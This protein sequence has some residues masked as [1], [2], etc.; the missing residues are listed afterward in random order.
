MTEPITPTVL[1]TDQL[2][3]RWILDSPASE[4]R[5]SNRTFWRLATV[6]GRFESFHGE[7]VVDAS[8]D[9]PVH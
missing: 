9:S 3:G 5:I 6:K 7:G 4:I 8:G 2:V 1:T